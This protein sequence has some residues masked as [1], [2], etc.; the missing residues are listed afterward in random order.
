MEEIPERVY[1]TKIKLK[2]D[3][4]YDEISVF[5]DE[6][7]FGIQYTIEGVVYFLDEDKKGAARM[8]LESKTLELT[9]KV[10]QELMDGLNHIKRQESVR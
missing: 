7:A 9:D 1:N 10:N 3:Q 8:N 4:M 6:N 2:G 5:L